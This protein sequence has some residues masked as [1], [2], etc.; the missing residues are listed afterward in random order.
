MNN[1]TKHSAVITRNWLIL[2]I[3]LFLIGVLINSL[4][5]AFK[6]IKVSNKNLEEAE[7]E[8]QDLYVRGQS[9]EELLSNFEN[10]FGFEKYVRENFGV[11]KPGEKIVI[12]V[13]HTNKDNE[14]REE[15]HGQG[16]E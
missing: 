2:I 5:G 11:V 15:D 16:L 8:Y 1:H 9:I 4:F 10:N 7:I 3:L 14:P 6:N 12:I 13:N